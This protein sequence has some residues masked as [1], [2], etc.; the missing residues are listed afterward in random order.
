[1]GIIDKRGGVFGQ[2]LTAVHAAN[3]GKQQRRKEDEEVEK[4]VDAAGR[5][6]ECVILTPM[7]VCVVWLNNVEV[8][9]RRSNNY[10]A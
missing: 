6:R 7:R 4:R 5:V 3:E 8:G 1:M 9:R 10:M 2:S